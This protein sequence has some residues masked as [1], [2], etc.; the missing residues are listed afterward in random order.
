MTAHRQ[1]RTGRGLFTRK[2]ALQRCALAGIALSL[3]LQGGC[4]TSG[5]AEDGIVMMGEDGVAKRVTPEEINRMSDPNQPY[6]LQVGDVLNLTFG[7][8]KQRAGDAPW[9]YRIEPGDSMEVRFL[10]GQIPPGNYKLETGDV[11][12]ISFLDN[13]Q[14]NVTRAVRPDGMITAP[15]VGDVI[16]KG[17]SALE[18][19]DKLKIIYASSGILGGEAR[20]SV[21]VDFVNLDRYE[22][23]SRDVVVRP[24]G[25]IRLPGIN[26]DL[27]IGGLTVDAATTLVRLAASEI[28]RNPPQVSLLLL[29]MADTPLLNEMSVAA[30]VR[31]D[32]RVSV[33]RIGEIQAAGYSVRTLT[34]ALKAAVTGLMN[35]PIEP[36]VDLL[37]STGGRIYV[38][39]QVNRPGVY[40]LEGA[41]T[42]LQAVITANGFNDASRLN[43]V[44]VMRRNPEGKP[45]IFKTNLRAALNRGATENDIPLRPFDIVYVPKKTISK[46]NTYVD[47]YIDRLVPFDNTLGINAQYYL[48]KQKIDT[49]GGGVVFGT[50]AKAAA[51]ILGP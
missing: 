12:G 25:C 48:N 44:I 4:A 19:R 32:G 17:R 39:G 51:G 26:K 47:Q 14:L 33:P 13:W 7:M 15:E 28:L 3:L 30:Q 49:G 29:T 5:D 6:L 40:P 41:P 9:K 8:R 38:G 24:D 35:N 45:F 16:A 37:K 18:L 50:G 11:V 10:P 22:D 23:M 20:I 2:G 43:N 1:S 42:A 46:L 21:N 36:G 27:R 34:A 31:P